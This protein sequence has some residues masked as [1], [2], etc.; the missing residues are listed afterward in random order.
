MTGSLVL[1]LHGARDEHR[2][3]QVPKVSE[4]FA[5]ALRGALLAKG[6]W[7]GWGDPPFLASCLSDAA[8]GRDNVC[9]PNS[10]KWIARAKLLSVG[11]MGSQRGDLCSEQKMDSNERS[12]L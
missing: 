11:T 5:Q 8:L 10:S 12:N 7:C 1:D 9:R 3:D 2:D 6:G 4:A